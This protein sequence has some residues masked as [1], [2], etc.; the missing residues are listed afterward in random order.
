MKTTGFYG[1]LVLTFL[2]LAGRPVMAVETIGWETLVPPVDESL[3]PYPR[4]S[5]DEQDSLY[6]LW[7][8]RESRAAGSLSEELAQLEKDAIANLEAGG[9]DADKIMRE[10]D[11]FLAILDANKSRLVENLDG[12][13]VR[14]PGYVLP[15]EYSGDTVVEFLLVP[16]VGACVH[17]PPPPLNQMVHVRVDGGF[18]NQGLFTPVWVTGRIETA[19]STQSISFTD[20]AMDVEAGY[21][22]EASNVVPY[23]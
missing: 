2:L 15:T 7:M 18:A 20:G 13:D 1:A 4:L 19:M 9:Y 23:E 21:K 10:L 14:I 5:E 3:D 22:I 11:A 17:T 6:D 8:V 16:Y 12:K